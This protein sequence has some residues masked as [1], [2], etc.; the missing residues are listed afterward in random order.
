MRAYSQEWPLPAPRYDLLQMPTFNSKSSFQE[1]IEPHY[2][3]MD[4]LPQAVN[5]ERRPSIYEKTLLF[6]RQADIPLRSLE[7]LEQHPF[8]LAI[9]SLPSGRKANFAGEQEY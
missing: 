4:K 6:Y 9:L 3:V 5:A 8:D 2:V 1:L 7:P